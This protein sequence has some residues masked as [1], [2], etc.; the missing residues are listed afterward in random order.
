MQKKKNNKIIIIIT[1][2][3]ATHAAC[4]TDYNFIMKDLASVLWCTRVC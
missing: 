3:A 2:T 4:S 1:T